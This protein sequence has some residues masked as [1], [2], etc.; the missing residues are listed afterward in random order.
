MYQHG[1]SWCLRDFLALADANLYGYTNDD[2]R[3]MWRDRTIAEFCVDVTSHEEIN[4]SSA[5]PYP[6]GTC[7]SSSVGYS[8]HAAIATL[9]PY[10][11]LKALIAA[12]LR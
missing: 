3:Q 6:I 9:E 11:G 8:W 4:T 10:S 12:G 5:G 7:S 2:V 1:G